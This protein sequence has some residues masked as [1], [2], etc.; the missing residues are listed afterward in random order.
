MVHL[1]LRGKRLTGSSEPVRAMLFDKDG[2][3]SRSE[4][5]LQTLAEARVCRCLT[6]LESRGLPERRRIELR[7]LLE[8]AYG[9]RN[10]G[11]DPAGTTA[12][13]ARDH[14][15]ISTATALA[16]IGLGWPEALALSEEVFTATD[17]LHGQGSTTPP[18]PTD[19]LAELLEQ[20]SVAGVRCAVISNDDLD[21]IQ[22][23]L[24]SHGLSHHFQAHWSAE[25]R[26]RKP[27]PA[28]VRGLCTELGVDPAACA[29]IGDADSD[30]AMGRRAG[31]GVVLGYVAGWSLAPELDPSFPVLGH[32][33]E[34]GVQ[35]A[36]RD[37]PART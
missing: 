30:L 20:L 37:Q 18:Q 19:G 4:P 10:G 32:W 7:D 9:L 27:D 29:L 23:F 14:N 21:G 8:R 5:M 31:V 33:R 2:T 12:V 26:P 24:A 17:G 13:A 25:H 34:L 22:R 3:L 11:L 16:Q 36:T 1:L 15:L 6:L 28:A 35:P